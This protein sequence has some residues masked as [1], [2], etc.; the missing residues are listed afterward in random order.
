MYNNFTQLVDEVDVTFE[1]GGFWHLVENTH[2]PSVSQVVGI[3]HDNRWQC[4]GCGGWFSVLGG[5]AVHS[6]KFPDGRV[7]DATLGT[8]RYLYVGSFAVISHK[9]VD[10]N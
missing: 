7:W 8:F 4:P 10:L 1:E 6:V 3:L 2:S 5:A 9:S